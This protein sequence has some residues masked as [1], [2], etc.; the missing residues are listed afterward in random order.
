MPERDIIEGATAPLFDRL[1]ATKSP[2]EPQSLRA[3]DRQ[4]LRESVRWELEQL[5]NTRSPTP[6][7]LYAQRELTVVDYGI[8]NLVNFAP[9]D[10]SDRGRL[11][12]LLS[13][14]VQA[15]EPRLRQVRV[16]VQALTGQPQA[17]LVQIEAE[18]VARSFLE[19]VH[20]QL[21]VSTGSQGRKVQVFDL[22]LMPT[23]VV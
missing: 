17:L 3:M 8:P 18:L 20:Y 7:R 1:R 16:S 19:P 2:A 14:A 21:T 23:L 12:T 11:G 10:N 4:A 9:Y 6:M 22:Q 5:F 15:F 13:R